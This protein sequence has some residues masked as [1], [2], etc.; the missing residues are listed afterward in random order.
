M[1][2]LK[3]GMAYFYTQSESCRLHES[4][5]KLTR[6]VLRSMNKDPDEY[7]AQQQP[8]VEQEVEAPMGNVSNQ[9]RNM[10]QPDMQ[11]LMQNV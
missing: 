2:A 10:A 1:P 3:P 8:Q 5:K 11:Q 4:I 9:M 7:F 6:E